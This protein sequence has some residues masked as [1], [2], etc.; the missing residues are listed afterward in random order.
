MHFQ[1]KYYITNL[2]KL[3]PDFIHVEIETTNNRMK[4]RENG[5]FGALYANTRLP[6]SSVLECCHKVE[7]SE[8]KTTKSELAVEKSDH[9]TVLLVVDDI[10]QGRSCD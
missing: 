6:H 10:P 3:K 9:H 7:C 1:T 2:Y 5:D 4:R 8:V